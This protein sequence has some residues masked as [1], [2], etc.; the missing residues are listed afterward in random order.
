MSKK[1]DKTQKNQSKN[2]A[3]IKYHPSGEGWRK[4]SYVNGKK[5]GMKFAWYE[6]GTKAEEMYY[7]QLNTSTT[8]NPTQYSPHRS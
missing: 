6:N 5:H 8:T 7:L 1:I 4:T 3:E 2:V